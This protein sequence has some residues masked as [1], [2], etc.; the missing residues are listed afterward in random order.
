MPPLLPFKIPRLPLSLQETALVGVTMLWGTT[1]LIVHTAMQYTGPMF[2]VGFRFTTAGLLCL[3]VFHRAMRGMTWQ[4]ARAGAAI[5]LSIFLG[6]GLQ[7]HGLQ[8]V[9]ASQSAF[10]TALYV[11]TV[12]LLQWLVLRSAPHPMSWLG[13]ALAFTGLVMLTS[14]QP[15]AGLSLGAGEL[16]S[17]LGAFVFAAEIILIGKYAGKVNLQRVTV[18]QL[19]VGGLLSFAAMPVAGESVPEFSWVWLACA[20]GLGTASVLIQLTMN[21]AQKAVSPTR[22][23]LIYAGEP[24]WGGLIGRLAG[25]RLPALALLGAGLIVLGAVVSELR[26]RFRLWARWLAL[27]RQ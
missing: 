5:G 14:P 26:P 4:E 7:T 9:S 20:L 23:T 6:Y 24:I 18:V 25:G 15:Q 27:P 2:F 21:W 11:P 16:A 19:L 17:L 8:S 3:L 12:P 22:A 10:I 1:F 13:I